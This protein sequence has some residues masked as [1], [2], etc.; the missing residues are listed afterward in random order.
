MCEFRCCCQIDDALKELT[1][2][3]DEEAQTFNSDYMF[4]EQE[5]NQGITKFQPMLQHYN[6]N[7]ITYI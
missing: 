2:G 3:L 7:N 6:I 4:G 5:R 1:M